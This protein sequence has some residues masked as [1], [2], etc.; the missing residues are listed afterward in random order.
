MIETIEDNETMKAFNTMI[1][2]FQHFIDNDLVFTMSNTKNFLLVKDSPSLKMASKTGDAIPSGCAADVCLR[3]KKVVNVLVPEKV[4]GVP[5]KT[6]GIPVWE[7]NQI[8][9]TMVIGM[10]MEKKSNVTKMS[11]LLDESLLNF[12]ERLSSMS[13]V[14]AE[15]FEKNNDIENLLKQTLESYK[16]TDDVLRFIESIAKQTNML[17][18]NAAIESVRAGEYGKGFSVVSNEIRTLSKSS[19]ESV[20]KIHHILGDIENS[21]NKIYSR[22]KDSNKLLENQNGD[23]KKMNEMLDGLNETAATLSTFADKM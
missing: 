9:G 20:D 1:P 22:F 5:L 12:H 8:A 11:K 16:Q 18:L 7:N 17:G 10:S 13:G 4:F 21:I 6:V 15:I 2:Y 23:L 14:I 3:Q 19:S